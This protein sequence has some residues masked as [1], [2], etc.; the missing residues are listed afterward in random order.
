[1]T[2]K[3]LKHAAPWNP[4]GQLSQLP[5]DKKLKMGT[6][7]S[8]SNG[9]PAATAFVNY[10]ARA[11]PKVGKLLVHGSTRKALR[12]EMLLLRNLNRKR[13]GRPSIRERSHSHQ[14]CRR[15]AR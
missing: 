5:P 4:Y 6:R 8:S 10:R 7:L 12:N 11:T 2:Y 15:C 9:A 14:A 1:M 3:S 13:A